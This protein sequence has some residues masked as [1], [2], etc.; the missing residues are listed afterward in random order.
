[1]VVYVGLVVMVGVVK[2]PT[3][4]HARYCGR[5]PLWYQAISS[6]STRNITMACRH[7]PHALVPH[8]S[9]IL[10]ALCTVINGQLRNSST[11]LISDC[12]GN[13]STLLV[14][15]SPQPFVN[16]RFAHGFSP[17]Y[18]VLAFGR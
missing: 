1:M 8:R 5:S 12:A 4:R 9:P 2:A 13:W 10:V 16:K 17:R 3:V 11:T 6:I 14:V 18:G 15:V 7:S